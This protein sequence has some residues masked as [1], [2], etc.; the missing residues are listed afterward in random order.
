MMSKW[1]V[2][3]GDF[4]DGLYKI[5]GPFDTEEKAGDYIDCF[6]MGHRDKFTFKLEQPNTFKGMNDGNTKRF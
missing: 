4:L 2:V 5:V 6:N 3:S 1:V